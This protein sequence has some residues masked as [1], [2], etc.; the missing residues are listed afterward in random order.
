MQNI[1][2][3]T[4]SAT[5]ISNSILSTPISLD[6]V[7]NDTRDVILPYTDL[8]PIGRYSSKILS[9][10]EGVYSNKPYIDCVHELADEDEKVFVVKF[11]FF[12]PS[13]TDAL[14]DTLSSYRLTGTMANVLNGLEENVTIAPRPGSTKYVYISSR[15]LVTT[16]VPS[17]S[18]SKKASFGK[19]NRFG[20]MLKG[21]SKPQTRQSLLDDDDDDFDDFDEADKD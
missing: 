14:L 13:E 6:C 4:T 7:K 18:P 20:S 15:A 9:A 17:S 5:Q 8:L 1:N 3:C 10:S 19:R 11:R 16:T 21:S 2:S 12:A